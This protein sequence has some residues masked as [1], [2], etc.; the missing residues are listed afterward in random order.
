VEILLLVADPVGGEG[1]DENAPAGEV[2][3]S[4]FSMVLQMLA[5]G[6]RAPGLSSLTHQAMGGVGCGIQ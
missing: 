4:R 6:E 3:M 2:Q 1:P 5:E